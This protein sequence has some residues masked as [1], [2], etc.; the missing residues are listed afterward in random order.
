MATY[1]NDADQIAAIRQ[2][3]QKNARPVIIG[4]MVGVGLLVGWQAW[5]SHQLHQGMAASDQFAALQQVVEAGEMT[6]ITA[7]ADQILQD[8]PGT[9][10]AVLAA[11][12]AAR[13]MYQQGDK[14]G[15][16]SWLERA[17]TTAG[18]PVLQQAIRVQLTELLIELQAWQ[19]A[20]QVLQAAD[21]ASFVAQ[22][23]ELRGDLAY[24]QGDLAAARIAYQQAVSHSREQNP[25]LTLKASELGPEPQQE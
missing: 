5:Q 18:E 7:G 4:V 24:H 11:R 14:A 3:W 21:E 20:E 6:A 19:A 12:Q 9:V 8:Y 17:L 10:Y 23:A 16:R 13:A 2:W 1:H 22:L 25:L 15:A